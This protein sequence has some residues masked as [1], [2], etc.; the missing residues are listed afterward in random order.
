[1]DDYFESIDP[2]EE[3]SLVNG[4]EDLRWDRNDTQDYVDEE[5]ISWNGSLYALK[6]NS[7]AR[8]LSFMNLLKKDNLIYKNWEVF[9]KKYVEMLKWFYLVYLNYD[10]LEKIPPVVGVM[11]INLLSLHKIVASFGGYLCVIL[12]DKWKTIANLQG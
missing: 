1:M 7:F 3:C 2:K 6:V 10:M 8:F 4:L 9:S 5:Y 12:G 11:E